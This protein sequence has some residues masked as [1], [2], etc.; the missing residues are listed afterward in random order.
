MTSNQYNDLELINEVKT[1]ID[2]V[3]DKVPQKKDMNMS[4]LSSLIVFSLGCIIGFELFVFNLFLTST[5]MLSIILLGFF[6]IMGFLMGI[7]IEKVDSLN[8]SSNP[9]YVNY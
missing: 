2:E 4:N 8:K 6:F 1:L 5:V 3:I 7:Y 9:I